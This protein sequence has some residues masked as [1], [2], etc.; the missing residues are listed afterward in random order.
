MPTTYRFNIFGNIMVPLFKKNY[1]TPSFKYWQALSSPNL[2]ESNSH[3]VPQ[4]IL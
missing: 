3:T 1:K 2:D 4:C